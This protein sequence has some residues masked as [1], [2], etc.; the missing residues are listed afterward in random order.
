MEEVYFYFWRKVSLVRSVVD[1][2]VV[3]EWYIC[4]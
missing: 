1:S 3:G 4:I 2:D